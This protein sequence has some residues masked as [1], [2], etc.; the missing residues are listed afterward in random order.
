MAKPIRPMTADEFI[1]HW[2]ER[3]IYTHLRNPKHQ[4]RL[5]LCAQFAG[6]ARVKADIGSAMGH[7]TDW[8]DTFNPGGWVG[9]DFSL[10]GIEKAR[11]I[12][13]NIPYEFSPTITGIKDALMDYKLDA[14]I[15]SE[16]IEHIEEDKE[17]I[18]IL[19]GMTGEVLIITTPAKKVSEPSHLRLY[20]KESL[21]ALFDKV[22]P[23]PGSLSIMTIGTFF[24]AV[25][26][27]KRHVIEFLTIA[28]VEN[29][30][31]LPDTD[32]LS[33]PFEYVTFPNP[34]MPSSEE[35]SPSMKNKGMTAPPECSRTI[36]T[37]MDDV[38]L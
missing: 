21:A 31:A 30:I 19:W 7:S 10:H 32:T 27:K 18:E 16:L 22:F 20:T 26:R 36:L 35:L 5:F 23:E 14:I 9:A 15:C 33:D 37:D 12:F 3:K 34:E 28:E 24:Y 11:E 13:P 1:K 25:A 4:E 17:L 2:E 8:M 6:N 38:E 29:T